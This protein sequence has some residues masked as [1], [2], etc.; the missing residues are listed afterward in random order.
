MR[1]KI[2]WYIEF[3]G[4]HFTREW[5]DDIMQPYQNKWERTQVIGL[6]SVLIT[7]VTFAA[8]F[9]VPGGDNQENG[10][11]ILGKRYVFKA[12]TLANAA[13]FT[14]AFTSL[15][16]LVSSALDDPDAADLNYA[17]YT[18]IS[19]AG[20]MVVAFALGSYVML[21]PVSKGIA[22]LIL[23]F[24]LP[25]GS[26]VMSYFIGGNKFIFAKSILGCGFDKHSV[27]FGINERMVF[28]VMLLSFLQ[29]FLFAL[30]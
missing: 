17:T 4:P 6:G 21:S 26:P 14:Q 28:N 20:C 7:T 8:A 3:H 13:S 22:V 2:K 16:T 12:F 10:T 18:F 1:S 23:L 27:G 11:P 29:I 25:L 5:F 30:I 19:A 15:F 24:S 9:T